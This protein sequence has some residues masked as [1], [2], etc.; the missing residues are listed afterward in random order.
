[1]KEILLSRTGKIAF[2]VMLISL[3]LIIVSRIVLEI[4]MRTNSLSA[5]IFSTCY[6][7]IYAAIFLFPASVITLIIL[8]IKRS[9]KR[10]ISGK[11]K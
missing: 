11:I 8:V 3:L 1:M 2:S 7:V 6:V 4:M 9:R 5:I 10:R